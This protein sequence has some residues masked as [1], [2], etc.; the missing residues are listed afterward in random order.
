MREELMDRFGEIPKSVE[1]LLRISLIRVAAHRLYVTELK[2]RN[3][4]IILTMKEDARI[5]VDKIPILLEASGNRLKFSA[6]GVPVFTFRYQKYGVVEKDAELLMG[7]VEEL[8]GQM[9]M[10]IKE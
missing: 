3:G 1:N 5:L 2:G 9:Q 7:L 4:E 10:L 6:K 8:V